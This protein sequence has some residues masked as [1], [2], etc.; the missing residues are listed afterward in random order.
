[1]IAG[2]RDA[3]TTSCRIRVRRPRRRRK[4]GYPPPGR[5]SGASSLTNSEECSTSTRKWAPTICAWAQQL[6]DSLLGSTIYPHKKGPERASNGYLPRAMPSCRCR[7]TRSS[8]ESEGGP[9]AG[10]VSAD[11]TFEKVR[12]LARASEFTL[13]WASRECTR[14]VLEN[15]P[16]WIILKGVASISSEWRAG[17]GARGSIR[18][19][20]AF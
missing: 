5:R 15:V 2:K 20:S 6:R 10:I 16:S 3:Q 12:V 19:R 11:G 8:A 9:G 13:P 7:A 1:M 14:P 17:I 18:L 4:E